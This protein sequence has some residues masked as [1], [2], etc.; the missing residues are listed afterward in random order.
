MATVKINGTDTTTVGDLP[1]VGDHLPDFSLTGC[2]LQ[3]FSAAD[4]AGKNLVLN[5]FPSVDTGVCAASV[6]RF[7][8]EAAD[9]EDTTVVCISADLPF[10]QQRFCAA[11]G[12]ENVVTGSSFRSSFGADYGVTL[13]E[14]AMKGLLARTVIV[15]DTSGTITHVELV[16]EVTTE[17][18]Y[19]AALS[20]LQ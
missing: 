6:R 16:P 15:A 2:D 19:D 8:Q 20:A 17:P 9:L 11:E 18:D 7:N 14:G 13:A 1:A 4:Y 3:D 5:I 10:A 12:I